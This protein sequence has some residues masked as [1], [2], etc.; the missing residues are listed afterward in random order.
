MIFVAPVLGPLTVTSSSLRISMDLHFAVFSTVSSWP[1]EPLS[2]LS[3]QADPSILG[4][5]S[6]AEHRRCGSHVR[7][8][9]LLPAVRAERI[10]LRGCGRFALA[11]FASLSAVWIAFALAYL[12]IP[13]ECTSVVFVTLLAPSD[14]FPKNLLAPL[15]P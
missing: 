9:L 4:L 10:R 11:S 8:N 3:Y 14:P 6:G 7:W 5:K 12:A 2:P 1:W 15:P 13:S